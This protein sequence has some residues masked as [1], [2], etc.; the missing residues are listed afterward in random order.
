[1]Q[2]ILSAA[3]VHQV[4]AATL[5][6]FRISSHTLMEQAAMAFVTE[7]YNLMPRN[8]SI[9]ILCG[10][11]NNGGDGLAVARILQGL[12]NSN[13]SVLIFKSQN[14]ESP[15]FLINLQLLEKTPVHI[16]Y[17]KTDEL[18][19]IKENIIIDALIGI[20]LNRPLGGELLRLVNF[21][22]RQKKRVIAI[23]IPTG[24]P[25]EEKLAADYPVLAAK[26][27]ITFHL[28][29]LSFFFPESVKGLER[30]IVVDIGLDEEY[31]ASLPSDYHLLDEFDI[32]KVYKR[33]SSF[34]HK[35]TYGKAL[36][37]AGNTG[38]IGAGLLCSE[39][40]LRTGAGLTTACIPENTEMALNIRN[41]EI[42]FLK[43]K[44]LEERWD[45][46]T[47]IAIGPGLGERSNLLKIIFSLKTKPIVLDADAL[48]FLSQNKE[49]LSQLPENLILTPHMKEFDR[50]FGDSDTW[51]DRLQLAKERAKE[52][53][54][55]IV[56]KNRYTFIILPSGQVRINPTGNPAMA[57]GV[58]GDV[59]T[60]VIAAFLAQGYTAEEASMLGC[61][62]HG[63]AGDVLFSEGMGIVPASTLSVKI[64]FI[65]G[66]INRTNHLVL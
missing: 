62:I 4:D 19:I 2:K 38:T 20:G 40:C 54:I 32:S 28:P 1:M 50:L 49:L 24:M 66:E 9:L 35:G 64:P 31:I 13:V 59:L 53:N 21:I 57:N 45:E 27:V 55:I 25:S 3:Q 30:F 61:Y 46:F 11:G 22:N 7:L 56:L 41:P 18:P 39:A 58:M 23:D 34:S 47:A 6:K 60:G 15:D 43:E 65:I 63:R 17:W 48:N 10:T 16:A 52:Y 26:E 14:K 29:K 51:W 36:V 12:G 33:R 42:M 37:I 44:N 5:K 8:E